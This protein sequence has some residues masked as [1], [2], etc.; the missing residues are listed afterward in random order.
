MS[1][2]VATYT[3]LQHPS[4]TWVV[5]P[6]LQVT[7]PMSLVDHF[8]HVRRM[9]TT[10]VL[11]DLESLDQYVQIVANVYSFP[12]TVYEGFTVKDDLTIKYPED[13]AL[14]PLLT[15]KV[16]HVTAAIYKGSVCYLQVGDDHAIIN[17]D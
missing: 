14:Q 17:L 11:E 9:L 2:S 16:K 7:C 4:Y 12:V 1:K 13:P 5:D 6:F 15:L 8:G 3:Q 10:P